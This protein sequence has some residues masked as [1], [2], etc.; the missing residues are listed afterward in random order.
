MAPPAGGG[1]QP[2]VEAV[3][4]PPPPPPLP[5]TTEIDAAL[6]AML[7]GGTTAAAAAAPPG[8]GGGK[9]VREGP[10]VGDAGGRG[11]TPELANDDEIDKQLEMALE[12][13]K[14]KHVVA[15]STVTEPPPFCKLNILLS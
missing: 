13:K 7:E 1:A 6:D 5:D 10:G 8:E 14:V 11:D 12:K 15:A 2:A 9:A 3:A 4:P